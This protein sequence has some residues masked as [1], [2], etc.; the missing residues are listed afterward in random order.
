MR[1]G[2]RRAWDYQCLRNERAAMSITQKQF[3]C[4]MKG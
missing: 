2:V 3:D 1:T 4:L